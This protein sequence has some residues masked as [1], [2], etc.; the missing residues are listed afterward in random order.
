MQ[1]LYIRR[2]YRFCTGYLHALLIVLILSG[3]LAPRMTAVLAELI[4]GVQTMIICTGERMVTLTIGADGIPVEEAEEN[5]HDCVIA[6]TV[7]LAE[8]EQPFWTAL[9]RD[10]DHRFAIRENTQIATVSLSLLSPSRA[11][12]VLV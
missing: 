2:M 8:V 1:A 3:F 7:S 10:F 11:P 6:D 9:S 12:P 4:P 5:E